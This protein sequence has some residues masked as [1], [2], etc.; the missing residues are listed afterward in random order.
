MVSVRTSDPD[1]PSRVLAGH[2]IE[3]ADRLCVALISFTRQSASLASQLSKCG[4]DKTSMTLLGALVAGGPMRASALA[5]AVYADPST[6]SRQVAA[7][8][9][10]GLI[11][12][13]AD[14]GDGR[15]TLLAV[16][17]EGLRLMRRMREWRGSEY[18]R[19]LAH[20][21]EKDR[22]RFV[23][24]FE[25]FVE[26]HEEYLPKFVSGCAEWARSGG[27]D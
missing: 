7:L 16:S 19:M 22:I 17:D 14:Q 2:D 9:K 8:V 26:E 4:V 27:G 24:L 3:L 21:P 20:W 18:A 1:Q 25:R 5:E 11:I 23:E 12:R 13:M 6:I 10:G 15:A